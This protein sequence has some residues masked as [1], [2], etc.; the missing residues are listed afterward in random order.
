M[1]ITMKNYSAEFD[2]QGR[3][4]SVSNFLTGE[5]YTVGDLGELFEFEGYSISSGE[6]IGSD[7]GE[8][9]CV[10]RY[11]N[12]IQVVWEFFADYLEKTA[13]IEVADD[14]VLNRVRTFSPS[15]EGCDEVHYHDDCTIWHCP[16]CYYARY[17]QGGMFYGLEYPYW[18]DTECKNLAFSP[19]VSLKKGDTFEAEKVFLGV[20]RK[21]NKAV[22]S[23]GPYPGKRKQRYTDMFSPERCGLKQHFPDCVIPE[24]C[25]IPE[26]VQD[27]GEIR[28]MQDF[29]RSY[30]GEMMLPEEGYFVWQNG[31]WAGLSNADTECIDVLNEVGIHDIMT[32]AIYFGHDSHPCTEPKYI[33]DTRISPLGFPKD[34]GDAAKVELGGFHRE[35]VTCESERTEGGEYTEEFH[36]PREYEELIRYGEERN[37]H[38]TSF[39]TPNNAYSSAPEWEAKDEGGNTYKYFGTKLSCPACGEYMDHHFNVL[40]SIFDKYNTRLWPFDGRNM[41][42][43]EVAVGG[44]PII[45]ENPCFAEGHGHIPGKSRY[46]EWKNLENFKRKL[47]ERYPKTCFENYYGMK[48]G[49]TWS[50]RYFNSDENYYECSCADDNRFQAWHNEMERFRP[51]YMQYSPIMGSTPEQLEYSLISCLSM[52]SY[53]QCAFGYDA[54]RDDPVCREIYKKWKRWGDENIRYL[55]KRENLFG[56]PGDVAVDASAHI[57]D[58]EGYIFLFCTTDEKQVARITFSEVE[59]LSPDC[60]YDIK[61]VF[62]NNGEVECTPHSAEIEMEPHT[63]AV[64]EFRIKR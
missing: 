34:A 56:C 15:F 18:D 40:C 29:F 42:Y 49:S 33:R 37:V 12:G 39:S 14:C 50:L 30:L 63:A 19:W 41:G 48:R 20:Y 25:G 8:N 36:A 13:V 7:I 9:R 32:A 10:F 1:V 21:E 6:L 60:T 45:G 35:T 2:S 31:W 51:T 46:M 61:A 4:A 38:V 47:R 53:S 3:L 44:N 24:D 22:S 52:S 28:A 11:D 16:M 5:K 62:P 23:H 27:M 57:I 43:N 17:G 59:G 64:L 55:K 54:L 26:E 58:G